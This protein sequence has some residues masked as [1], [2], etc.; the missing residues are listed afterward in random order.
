MKTLLFCILLTFFRRGWR[1]KRAGRIKSIRVRRGKV[2]SEAV[3]RSVF[4]TRT[5][6]TPLEGV[7]VVVEDFARSHT[8]KACGVSHY[9]IGDDLFGKLFICTQCG[10]PQEIV[11][12]EGL[13]LLEVVYS[14][15]GHE[16]LRA[17]KWEAPGGG[18]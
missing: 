6:S 2:V 3:L 15:L 10:W 4:V 12:A 11:E 5:A 14:V 18:I 16:S 17:G 8:C 9:I 13:H 7:G 1:K